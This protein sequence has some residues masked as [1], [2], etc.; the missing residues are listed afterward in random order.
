MSKEILRGWEPPSQSSMPDLFHNQET[1]LHHQSDDTSD[2]L[3]LVFFV[4]VTFP[5][6]MDTLEPHQPRAINH[7]LLIQ[8]CEH[9]TTHNRRI[10]HDQTTTRRASVVLFKLSEVLWHDYTDESGKVMLIKEHIQLALGM[11]PGRQEDKDAHRKD[12]YR[13]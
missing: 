3:T 11:C 10:L 12:T 7:N 13:L 1:P 8:S 9:C 4:S 2:R 6:E 5:H